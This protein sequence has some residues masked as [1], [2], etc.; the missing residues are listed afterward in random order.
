ME[1]GRNLPTKSGIGKMKTCDSNKRTRD[2]RSVRH[3][4]IKVSKTK[5]RARVEALRGVFGAS[6]EFLG[7]NHFTIPMR[8]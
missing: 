6:A 1:E 5:H 2:V 3:G 8:I 7:A 4:G